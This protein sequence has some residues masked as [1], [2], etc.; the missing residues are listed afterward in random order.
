RHGHFPL[1][2]PHAFGGAP[3]FANPQTALLFPLTTLAYVL[4]PTTA[5]GLIAIL[6]LATAGLG[7]Y[8]FLRL[9][10]LSPLPAA[11]GALTYM[12]SAMLTVWLLWSLASAMIMLPLLFATTE[13]LRRRGD[14]RSLAWLAVA[15]ALMLL[16]GYP[17]TA[18]HSMLAVTLYALVR[19]RGAADGPRP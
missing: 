8:W 19:A 5:I 6:K 7:M 12:L 15:V 10:S 13:R 2:N 1:W 4:P 16:A 9:L 11:G 3:F 17:Q 18:F 14:A